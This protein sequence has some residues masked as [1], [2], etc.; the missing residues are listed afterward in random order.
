MARI[1]KNEE[2]IK[3]FF[4]LQMKYMCKSKTQPVYLLSKTYTSYFD[5]CVRIM[6]LENK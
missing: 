3:L 1:G 6:N 4:H 2:D 5:H